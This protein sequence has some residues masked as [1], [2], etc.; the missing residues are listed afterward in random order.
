KL[1]PFIGRPKNRFRQRK[2][3]NC[4]KQRYRQKN[5]TIPLMIGEKHK[6]AL[7]QIFTVKVRCFDTFFKGGDER[8]L[9]L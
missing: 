9:S 8:P 6:T 3:N 4:I 7:G 1:S 5:N 2:K